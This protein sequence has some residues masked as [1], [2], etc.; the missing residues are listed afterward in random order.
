MSK[1][2]AEPHKLPAFAKVDGETVSYP[3]VE[4]KLFE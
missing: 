3:A 2:R 4:Q 1:T